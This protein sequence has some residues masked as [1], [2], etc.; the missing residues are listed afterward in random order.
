MLNWQTDLSPLRNSLASVFPTVSFTVRVD[1]YARGTNESSS[2][3]VARYNRVQH[4]EIA[5]TVSLMISEFE[6]S[7]R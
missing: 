5:R 7:A 6:Q 1:S 4:P 2:Q 3:I